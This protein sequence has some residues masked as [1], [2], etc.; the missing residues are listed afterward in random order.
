MGILG[1]KNK[2]KDDEAKDA[3]ALNVETKAKEEKAEIA[4]MAEK[5]ASKV[6][7]EEMGADKDVML[8]KTAG[9]LIRPIISEKNS[10]LSQLN[11]YVFEV[12]ADANKI[13]IAQ[14]IKARYGVE[15]IKVNVANYLGKYKRYGRNFGKQKDTRKAVV[16][17]AEGKSISI[18]E[19]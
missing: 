5:K 14:A 6:K 7:K 11:Q 4:D 16:F 1:F 8:G 18:S 10:N 2:K 12:S 17:L 15:P 9:I 19:A 3:K 13:Q